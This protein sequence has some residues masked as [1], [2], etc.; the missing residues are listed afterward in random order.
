MSESG[1]RR[2]KRSISVDMNSVKF[3][4]DVTLDRFKRIE[5]ISD[6][7]DSRQREIEEYNGS[8]DFDPTVT[9]NGRRLTNLGTFRHYILSYLRHHP[10]IHPDMTLLVRQLAPGSEG[11]PIEI[12][13]FSNDQVWASY[14]SIQADI[15]DHLL[16]VLPEFDLRVYQNPSG[17]DFQSGLAPEAR[18]ASEGVDVRSSKSADEQ[19]ELGREESVASAREEDGQ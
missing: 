10:R 15:F 13:C 16:A 11:L 4:D 9:V 6:Y 19:G 17:L 18:S 2:I 8:R 12:Y 7:I 5:F 14:E 1:G 3:C